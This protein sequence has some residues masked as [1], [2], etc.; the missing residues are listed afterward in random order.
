MNDKGKY[1][2]IMKDLVMIGDLVYK[3]DFLRALDLF[4]IKY[5]DKEKFLYTFEKEYLTDHKG[6]W[7]VSL[8]SD[9]GIPRSNNGNEGY[10]Q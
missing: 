5:G 10:N 1:P 2:G 8:V 9:Y 7:S 3:E 4:H 6:H